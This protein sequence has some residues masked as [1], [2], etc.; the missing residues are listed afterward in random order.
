MNSGRCIKSIDDQPSGCATKFPP[1][2]E[3]EGERNPNR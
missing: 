3:G 2:P 1:L